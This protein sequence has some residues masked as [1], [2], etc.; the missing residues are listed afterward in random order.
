M[1][2]W[3]WDPQEETA[4]LQM[5]R[6]VGPGCGSQPP[7]ADSSAHSP[8]PSPQLAACR[9]GEISRG[10]TMCKKMHMRS[11]QPRRC[12]EQFRVWPWSL[13]PK[14]ELLTQKALRLPS[15]AGGQGSGPQGV[16]HPRTRRSLSF[17][18]H[19]LQDEEEK[20]VRSEQQALRHPEN[21]LA[22][23]S[24]PGSHGGPENNRHKIKWSWSSWL[25]LTLVLAP[26]APLVKGTSPD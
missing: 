8:A 20:L 14:S 19:G 24:A 25:Q 2:L 22:A 3:P 7:P 21:R 18:G 12:R 4:G 23:S 13:S 1:R 6:W 10:K 26:P 5:P 9:R 11:A 16:Y 15:E 17:A